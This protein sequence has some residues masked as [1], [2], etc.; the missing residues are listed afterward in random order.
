MAQHMCVSCGKAHGRRGGP[1][2]RLGCAGAG[3]APN[4][5]TALAAEPRN[6]PE[7]GPTVGM[8]AGVCPSRTGS[9]RHRPQSTRGQAEIGSNAVEVGRRRPPIC[10]N[11]NLVRLPGV[12]EF[13]R[14]CLE[15][16]QAC[17][18]LDTSLWP[19]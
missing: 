6:V 17:P 14:T 7:R 8:R 3:R 13:G 1:F 2:H 5:L 9:D 4:N 16:G 19:G 12:R 11:M 15:L 18:Y 10:Q